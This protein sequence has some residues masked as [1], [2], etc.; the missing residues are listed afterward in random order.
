MSFA[1]RRRAGKYLPA[2]RKRP[3]TWVVP[4]SP[5]GDLAGIHRG[6]SPCCGSVASALDAVIGLVDRFFSL[7]R[8]APEIFSGVVI[9]RRS[10]GTL[11]DGA[12]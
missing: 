1:L 5:M 7:R 2:R 8:S 11:P 12:A 6:G 9:L 4:L 10:L 3:R